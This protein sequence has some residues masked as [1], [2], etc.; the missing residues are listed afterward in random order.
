MTTYQPTKRV[1][2]IASLAAIVGAT[3]ALIIQ[4][5]VTTFEG[6]K[7]HAYKDVVGVWTICTGETDNV[8]PTDVATPQQCSVQLDARLAQFASGVLQCTPI[9]KG[10]SYQLAAATSLA[11]N[12][13]IKAYCSSTVAR[14][15]NAGLL[16]SGCDAFG[17]WI[18]AGGKVVQ[19]LINRRVAER[20][21]C[22][23]GL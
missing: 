22:L 19:G 18:K 8:H 11:Y 2:G 12:I 17:L 9:L 10:R 7:L 5:N 1:A 14:R 6:T 4:A 16:R 13:G 21:L 3:A 20:A 23:N 15:F